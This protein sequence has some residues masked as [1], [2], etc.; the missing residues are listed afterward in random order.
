MGTVDLVFGYIWLTADT[1]S[2]VSGSI[3]FRVHSYWE[4]LVLFISQGLLGTF[5]KCWGVSQ[6]LKGWCNLE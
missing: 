5:W 1:V 4:D 3:W 6:I 2:R